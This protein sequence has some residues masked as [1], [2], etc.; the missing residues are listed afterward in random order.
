MV[1]EQGLPVQL[2]CHT[3]PYKN[4][5][6]Q[7]DGASQYFA[8]DSE[9]W[10][11]FQPFP[12]ASLFLCLGPSFIEAVRNSRE[13]TCAIAQFPLRGFSSNLVQRLL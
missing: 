13:R 12:V 10:S 2:I 8:Y 3:K 4:H 6:S 1:N 7:N 5:N 9:N 11:A